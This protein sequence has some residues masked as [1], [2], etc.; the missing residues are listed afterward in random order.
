MK[1]IF[2]GTFSIGDSIGRTSQTKQAGTYLQLTQSFFMA[3]GKC[4]SFCVSWKPSRAIQEPL[5]RFVL[6]GT[7]FCDKSY[8]LHRGMY[9]LPQKHCTKFSNEKSSFFSPVNLFENLHASAYD[10]YNCIYKVK[11]MPRMAT[12]NYKHSANPG[13]SYHRAH[14]TIVRTQRRKDDARFSSL[15]SSRLH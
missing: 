15:D 6:L 5:F 11:K 2:C 8:K 14:Y 4:K 10:I 12:L 3:K 7:Q 9:S 1:A 13:R